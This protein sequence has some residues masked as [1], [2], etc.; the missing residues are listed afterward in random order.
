MIYNIMLISL[1]ILI[2]IG[3][4]AGFLASKVVKGKGS[5]FLLNLVFGI[6]GSFIGGWL[7]VGKLG[8]S[9]FGGILDT[10]LIATGGAIILL[11]LVRLIFKK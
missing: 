9:I 1:L 8:I 10:I 2:G 3:V 6:V 5:G 4:L 7:F 11:F